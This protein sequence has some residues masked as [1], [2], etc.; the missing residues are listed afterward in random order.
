MTRRPA[1]TSTSVTIA[2]TNGTSA[3]SAGRG[4]RARRAAYGRPA[5]RTRRAV[6]AYH[7]KI[8]AVV[9]HVGDHA[10]PLARGGDDTQPDEL[11]VIEL[12]RV[13]HRRDLRR[14]QDEQRAAQVLSGGPV[15]DARKRDDKPA[16]MPPGRGHR[17]RPAIRWLG[18]QH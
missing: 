15:T 6:P 17:E 5:G 3:S 12:I 9:Q 16:R 1:A 8:L 7:Q 11:V 10:D 18:T 14:I 13:R 2:P 4:H